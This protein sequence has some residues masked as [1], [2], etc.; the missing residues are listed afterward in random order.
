MKSCRLDTAGTKRTL[1]VSVRENK[2]GD[3]I[4]L[5]SVGW[6]LDLTEMREMQRMERFQE[7][8]RDNWFNK[9]PL[10]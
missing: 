1:N 5:K 3:S 2:R 7:P 9:V 10:H 8:E 6:G 4:I